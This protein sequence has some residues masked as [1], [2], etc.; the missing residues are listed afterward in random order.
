[1]TAPAASSMVTTSW[2]SLLHCTT[3]VPLKVIRSITRAMM[4]GLPHYRQASRK[5]EPLFSRESSAVFR[6]VASAQS[7]GKT[8]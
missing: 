3:R 7:L 6:R 1:M 4:K 2:N 8:P 5:N